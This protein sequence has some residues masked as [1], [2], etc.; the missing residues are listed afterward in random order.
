MAVLN[1]RDQRAA[2]TADIAQKMAVAART[3]PKGKGVDVIEA[4]V[5]TAEHLEQL[6]CEM[7]AY[8]E[9]SGMKF[10]LRDAGN[11]RAAQ[12][13]L[14]VGTR[15]QL[16]GLNCGHCGFATCAEKPSAVPCEINA[17]D[18]GIALGS[19]VSLAADLRVDTRI[20]FS[21]GLAAQRLGLL[22]EG[23]GQVYAVPVSIASKSPLFDR[24]SRA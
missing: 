21:A 15:T 2:Q 9:E 18:V 3:A 12:A 11:V 7:E 14:I 6:A 4:A 13:V 19:A 23:V 10:F 16:Q 5:L 8:A 1:E 17:V 20:M 22:G 24:P